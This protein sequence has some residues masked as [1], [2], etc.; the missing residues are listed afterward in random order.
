M[1]VSTPW[2]PSSASC[3]TFFYLG[4]KSLNIYPHTAAVVGAKVHLACL[5][6]FLFSF[7]LNKTRPLSLNKDMRYGMYYS[8]LPKCLIEE[9]HKTVFRYANMDQQISYVKEQTAKITNIQFCCCVKAAI[10]DILDIYEHD[11]I[12]IKLYTKTGARPEFT[13]LVLEEYKENP[14]FKDTFFF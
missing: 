14:C 12:Q 6:S 3:L 2:K 9:K 4:N 13:T 1:T 11:C 8:S 7:F 5:A 10:G